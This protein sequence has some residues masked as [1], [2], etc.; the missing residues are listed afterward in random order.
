MEVSTSVLSVED[1]KTIYNLEVAK[2]DYF[3]IDVMD[4]KFVKNNTVEKMMSFSTEIKHVTNVPLDIHLMVEDVESFV[5][6]YE[7]L[8]PNIITFHYEANTNEK[9]IMNRINLIKDINARVGISIKPKTEV[10]EIFKFLPFVHVV[11][12]MTVEPGEG[13]QK[14]ISET[15]HKISTLKDYIAENDLE[16]DIEAD[17]GI[18]TENVSYLKESGVSV[19]VAGTAI[20]NSQNM[21]ETISKLRGN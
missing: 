19:V 2:T 9:V 14:L 13:G 3:H 18:N 17:G 4:G 6:A 15:V 11:L 10:S 1:I 21:A 8:L 12:V 16:V 5:S 7:G 20:V